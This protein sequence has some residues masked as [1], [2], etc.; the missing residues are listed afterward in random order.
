M[1]Y[2]ANTLDQ[3][4]RFLELRSGTAVRLARFVVL[5]LRVRFERRQLAALDDAR[6]ADIGYTRAEAARESARGFLD[7]P[8]HRKSA[9]YL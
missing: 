5:A 9:I 6:L 2:Y 3:S 4:E 7:I 1:S 8:E